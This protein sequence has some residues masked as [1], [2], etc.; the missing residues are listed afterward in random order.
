MPQGNLQKGC[1]LHAIQAIFKLRNVSLKLQ[2]ILKRDIS[3]NLGHAR[4]KKYDHTSLPTAANHA[5]GLLCI[6]TAG[7]H[8][9][10]NCVYCTILGA[11]DSRVGGETD[12]RIFVRM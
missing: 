10:K 1:I 9:R 2:A 8:T 6:N 3:F 4:F 11:H 12:A 5:H 7:K